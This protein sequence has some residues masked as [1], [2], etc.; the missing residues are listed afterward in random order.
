MYNFH[1]LDNVFFANIFTMTEFCKKKFN[2]CKFANFLADS[3]SRAQEL[4]NDVS[5]VIFGHKTLDLE[6]G[7]QID[8]TPQ[9][10]LVF[11]YP[12]RDRVN[13]FSY[14]SLCL[15]QSE[16]FRHKNCICCFIVILS[17]HFLCAKYMH[18]IHFGLF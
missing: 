8:P 4:S 13:I 17:V 10:I 9:H 16:K 2:I 18:F 1:F 5:F 14:I 15:L 3:K 11:K 6:G 7:G 12:S